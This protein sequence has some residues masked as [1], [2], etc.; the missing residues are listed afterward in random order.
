L[1]PRIRSRSI[2][3]QQIASSRNQSEQTKPDVD[4]STVPG[5]KQDGPQMQT[6][7]AA[8][9]EAAA[10]HLIANTHVHVPPNFSAFATAE[11]AVAAA[12]AEGARVLGISNFHDQQVYRRFADSAIAAG[13]VPVFGLEFITVVDDL[14]D[15]GIR[16]NDPGNPGRMYLCG[17]GVDPFREPSG[18]AAA[19]AD[20][21]RRANEARAAAM[22]GLLRDHF[23]A[24]GLATSLDD[25]AIVAD[26]A[27][28]AGVPEA[29][30]V[31]QE[32]HIA[33]AFQEA[34]FLQVPPER[35]AVLLARAYGR[36]P[37]APVED[38]VAVQGEIRSRLMKAGCPGFVAETALGFADAV[39]L[40]LEADG[41]PAYPTLADGASPVCPFE[42][43]P[44]TLARD[45]KARG[46]H[47]AE[48][49]PNRN[50]PEVVDAY[51]AAFRA[52]GIAVTAG[53]EHNTLDAIPIDPECRGG[54]PLS[55]AAR[56]VFREGTCVV[57]AHQHLR[58]RGRP[59]FV[60]RDG[61]PAPGFESDDARIRWFANVG[62]RIIAGQEETL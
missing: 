27:E 52:A 9:Q 12:R 53:T 32:R 49:I 7:R 37:S 15:A 5:T 3:S 26:V 24:A 10:G 8:T 39:R 19:I 48:L 41:I 25:R 47:L 31:L 28:R 14:R 61:V 40:V 30:V 51:V 13:I 34:L 44:G 17:K 50:E 1:S 11:A 57:V 18:E 22:T 54:R 20:G 36:A 56:A 59:G 46:L 29:W 58:A 38:P 55:A 42:A 60:D 23:A 35:R 43:S 4:A 16:V 45:L 21:A 2:R 33:M 62:E 6:T